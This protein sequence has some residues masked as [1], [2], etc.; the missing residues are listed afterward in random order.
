MV[1]GAEA[2]SLTVSSAGRF[3]RRGARNRVRRSW[4]EIAPTA[5]VGSVATPRPAGDGHAAGSALA[6]TE[7][8]SALRAHLSRV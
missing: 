6:T 2:A 8:I 3:A 5:A 7:L 1:D 4:L